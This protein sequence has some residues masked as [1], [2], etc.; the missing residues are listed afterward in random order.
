MINIDMHVTPADCQSERKS[1]W[2]GE[3]IR[4]YG[5]K[6]IRIYTGKLHW[7]KMC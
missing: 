4:H 3:T 6:V 7:W 2:Q 5:K 1:S